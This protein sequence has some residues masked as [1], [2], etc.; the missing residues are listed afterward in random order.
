PSQYITSGSVYVSIESEE[1]TLPY[2]I[3][4]FGEDHI[5]FASDYPHERSR[6]EFLSDIPKLSARED[7]S[8]S[9]K[10]KILA[11]NAKQFYRLT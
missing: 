8:S 7:I 2:V 11:E 9:A 3:Q 5:F 10:H 6:S 4:I 1:R